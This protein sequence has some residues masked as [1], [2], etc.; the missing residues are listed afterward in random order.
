M[1]YFCDGQD[2]CRDMSD[3]RDCHKYCNDTEQFFCHADLKCIPSNLQCNGH[4]DC[5]DGS[6]EVGCL[7]SNSLPPP[8]PCRENQF[9]CQRNGGCIPSK[10]VCDG[11]RD[12]SDGSDESK[13]ICNDTV[14]ACGP[15]ERSCPNNEPPCIPDVYWCDGYLDCADGS[16]ESN[17]HESTFCKYPNFKCDDGLN[18]TKCLSV[19]KLCDQVQDCKDGSDEGR[20]CFD[21]IC[22][23]G[24][25]DC[26]DYCHD[27]P[28]GRICYCSPG[29]HL[30]KNDLTQ[31]TEDH[32]CDQWGT[33]S[34]KCKIVSHRRHKC[35]CENGYYL[36]PDGFSCKSKEERSPLIVFSTRTE[37]RSIDLRTNTVKPLISSL[38]N[39]IVFDFIRS[40]DQDF[41]FWTDALDQ[42]IYRGTLLGGSLSNVIPIVEHGLS[43]AEGLAVDWIGDNIYWVD[44]SLDQI[45]VANINGSFR[46]TLIAGN[47]QSPRA[48]TLDPRVALLF[49][50]DWVNGSARIESCN[51]AGDDR[52]V[53]YEAFN[54]EE[55]AW[56]NGITLDY[57]NRRL[58]W[59][60]ARSDSIHTTN[61]DGSDRREILRDHEYLTHPFAITLFENYVYWTDWKSNSVVRANK[62]DGNDVKV[63]DRIISLPYDIRIIHPSRQPTTTSH[64]CRFNNGGCSHLC[65]LTGSQEFKCACPHVMKLHRDNKT[66]VPHE[67]AFL[68][69]RANEIRGVELHQ[70]YNHVIPPVSVASF[71]DDNSLISLDFSKK[72]KCFYII[73]PLEPRQK[74]RRASLNGSVVDT[75]VDNV[76]INTYAMAVDWISGNIFYSTSYSYEN[77]R[78][79]NENNSNIYVSNLNGEHMSVVVRHN[80][81]LIRGIVVSPSLGMLYWNDHDSEKDSLKMAKMDGSQ[82]EEFKTFDSMSTNIPTIASLSYS[83]EKHQLY[84]LNKLEQSVQYWDFRTGSLRTLEAISSDSLNINSIT[85]HLNFMYYSDHKMIYRLNLEDSSVKSVRNITKPIYSMKVF[86]SESQTGT[87]VCEENNGGCQHLCLPKSLTSRVCAC[88][89]GYDVTDTNQCTPTS[90]SVLIWTS[91]YGFS[92]REPE[93]NQ[94]AMSLTPMANLGYPTA[95]GVLPEKE[96]IFLMNNNKGTITRCKRDGTQRKLIL[97]DLQ[98]PQRLT[99]DWI[100]NNLYW[101]DDK[102]KVIEMSNIDGNNRFVVVS[103][104]MDKPFAITIDPT[105]GLLFWSDV[106]HTAK[107][108]RSS[109]DG[110][111]RESIVTSD[112]IS[113]SGLTLDIVGMRLFWCDGLLHQL[114]SV[115]YDG[116]HRRLILGK[117]STP[118]SVTFYDRHLYWLDVNQKNGSL[119]RIS[120]SIKEDSVEIPLETNLKHDNGRLSDLKIYT[121]KDK[122]Y[123]GGTIHKNSCGN[124]NGGCVEICLF[125]G[126]AAHCACSHGK[127]GE[128]G[129]SCTDYDA[130]LMYSRV[131]RIESLHMFNDSKLNPPVRPITNN[132]LMKNV[133]GLAYNHREKTLYYS[134]I[135][136]GSIHSVHYNGSNHKVLFPDLGAVEGLAYASIYKALYWTC[137]THKT[138]SRTVFHPGKTPKSEVV[139]RMKTEDQLRGIDVDSCKGKIY[140][141]NWNARAPSIQRSWLTGYGLETIVSTNIRMPNALVLDSPDRKMYWGDARLDKIERVDMDDLSRVVLTRASPQHPFDLAVYG[142]Y[143]FYTD[144]VLHAVVRVNKLTGEDFNLIKRDIPRPMSIVAIEKDAEECDDPCSV[145][146]GGCEDVCSVQNGDIKCSCNEGRT[147]I[148]GDSQRCTNRDE[149]CKHPFQF[150]CSEI[151]QDPI[152]IL[153]NLTCDG[154]SH[155]PDGSDEDLVYCAIRNCKANYL[156]CANGKCVQQNLK[157]NGRDDCGDFTDEA[158]C[159]CHDDTKFRCH[160]G[161]PCLDMDLKCDGKLDCIDVSDETNCNTTVTCEDI[162]GKP[163]INCLNTTACI[164]PEWIC[165]GRNDCWDNSDEANC[166][167]EN[168]TDSTNSV[169]PL[170]TYQCAGD[171]TCISVS[172]VCDSEKDCLDG[173][174]EEGCIYECKSDQFKCASGQCIQK[175]WKCDGTPDCDDGSDETDSCAKHICLPDKEFRCNSTGRCIP[176]KWVCDGDNDCDNEDENPELC[177]Q[178][179]VCT[180]NEFRCSNGRCINKLF[181]CDYNDDCRD[182]SDEP[183][184]CDY[185]FCPK[186]FFRC[187]NS[188]D[189]IPNPKLCDGIGDCP[190][191][192]DEKEEH[193]K[194]SHLIKSCPDISQF[195]CFNGGCV[196]WSSLCDGHNDCGDYSDESSCNV[197]ECENPYTCAHVCEDKTIGYECQCHEG[198]KIREDD[199]SMCDDIDECTTTYPCSQICLN[200]PGSY[201]CSCVNGY[202]PLDGGHRCKANETAK[203][204]Y[205]NG[206]YISLTDM[207]NRSELIVK[208]QSNTVALDFDWKNQ[209]IYWSDVTSKGSSL[210]KLCNYNDPEKSEMKQLVTLRNPDGLAVDWVANNLY[211]CD[212]GSDTIEVSDLNGHF[213]RILISNGLTEPRAIA[214]DPF[215]GFLYWSDWGNTPHIGKAGMDGSNPRTIIS[216]HLGWPN[217]IAIDYA[218]K[219]LFFGDARQDYI[220]VCDLEGQNIR[221]VISRGL[222]PYIRLHHIFALTVFEDYIYWSDWETRTIERCHKYTGKNNITITTSIHRPMDLQVF[223]LFYYIFFFFPV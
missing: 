26:S 129:V 35:Y 136:K 95:L 68:F 128:D 32:P 220:A 121:L 175:P 30:D 43:T 9:L 17:C 124:N 120:T 31:C 198:Y 206:Y 103:G 114:V 202:V 90:D 183:E 94:H 29:M 79:N 25:N 205:S 150:Q 207:R 216:E 181:Y 137:N 104:E 157:C 158:G 89:I 170:S 52:K 201:K 72:T 115:N 11:T 180:E 100:A 133:I 112:I 185:H 41:V 97:K 154:I 135:Q 88:A 109:L 21:Q 204:M 190:G 189:C 199:P 113:V 209:C 40:K 210:K 84:W 141:T 131:S 117:L 1:E 86:D 148:A 69:S 33:C 3:E 166:D 98:S 71:P 152:C 177:L 70:M 63:M 99:V 8:S 138:I 96:L 58:Y 159:E 62:W 76:L 197:N 102:L 24:R 142:N 66:C 118:F 16:D 28:D 174:D 10:F 75:L 134:D 44:S 92:G 122:A 74:I 42:K 36:E 18:K 106:G 144:W 107:I 111:N 27:S 155:C 132:N 45:E 2:D 179:N 57:V 153:Y 87:N 172:W 217:A 194:F 55:G 4:S 165:D 196:P 171:K 54:Y 116:T 65:L 61:Y 127:V 213:R 195:K 149:P 214:I 81:S 77:Y 143:L 15:K 34:Q 161:G 46:R 38:H 219:Q 48:I 151:L 51:M 20:R 184:T 147:P 91:S 50:T 108:E 49:W 160:Q 188:T 47:M 208:N 119:N 105:K 139:I 167:N 85:L 126:S 168:D 59:I 73:D 130:F 78:Q 223:Y 212:K 218:T 6:D 13:S 156:H 176:D 80:P 110:N 203:I 222:N 200:T 82:V 53:V 192:E 187:D 5:L 56:P 67:I 178:R 140:F 7:Y 191:A 83:S 93:I 193:C 125:N 19:D 23:R 39:T 215:Q 163:S 101:T 64:P 12:C 221:T 211:W 164:L 60:D 22:S 186:D 123:P 14:I 146:N 173:S 182:N 169:C 162:D 37:L 145:L